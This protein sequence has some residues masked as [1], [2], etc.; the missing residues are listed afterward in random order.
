[1]I[2]VEQAKEMVLRIT[3]RREACQVPLSQAYGLVLA[4]DI[5]APFDMP[6]F[7]NSAMDGYALRSEDILSASP[8]CPVFLDMI[9]EIPAGHIE[10]VRVGSGQCVRIMTGASLP[11]GA[12]VVVK[13]ESIMIQD[14]RIGIMHPYEK[15]INIRRQA[16]DIRKN[17]KIL[18]QGVMIKASQIA[19]LAALGYAK[20]LVISAPRVAVLS[21]GSELVALGLSLESSQIYDSN[22]YMLEALMKEECCAV[23][24]LGNIKDERQALVQ[25]IQEGLEYDILIVSGGVSVGE[26]DL[27]KDVFQSLKVEELFWKVKIKPGK[28]VFFGRK[29]EKLVFGLPGNPASSFV[30]FE[31]LVRPAIRKQMGKKVLEKLIVEAQL[32]EGHQ[33]GTSRKQYLR[34]KAERQEQGWSVS[35]LA[36]QGSHSLRSLAKANALV[37]IDEMSECIPRNG[38]VKVKLLESEYEELYVNTF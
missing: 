16:E 30:V 21:T 29:G 1:M 10:P 22:S 35:L 8:L 7:D 15:G 34:A 33:G 9:A 13:K 23:V 26:H 32:K 36:Q 11:V 25:H 6:R 28:P 18:S 27:V 37:I 17:E 4:E 3:Q 12:N 2:T 31:E 24:Q 5:M 14:K 20:V 38:Y 19:L